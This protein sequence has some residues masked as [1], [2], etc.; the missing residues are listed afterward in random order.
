M[1]YNEVKGNVMAWNGEQCR[2]V[3]GS[4]VKCIQFELKEGKVFLFSP[5]LR[6]PCLL[7]N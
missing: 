1:E 3:Q 5:S 2:E 7:T 6:L 4:A